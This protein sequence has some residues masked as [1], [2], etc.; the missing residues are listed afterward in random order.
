MLVCWDC[1]EFYL[2]G[3]RGSWAPNVWSSSV[4]EGASFVWRNGLPKFMSTGEV[5]LPLSTGFVLMAGLLLRLPNLYAFLY[6]LDFER[7]MG[8]KFDTTFDEDTW[9]LKTIPLSSTL[10]VDTCVKAY[11]VSARSYGSLV[12][13]SACMSLGSSLLETESGSVL[14]LL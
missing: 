10:V 9:S 8:L 12:V 5:T 1:S 11:L 3:E 7:V 6:A 14:R 2:R 13:L 4:I